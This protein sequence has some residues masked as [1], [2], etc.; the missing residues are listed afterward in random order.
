VSSKSHK[1]L[2]LRMI[3]ITDLNQINPDQK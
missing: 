1:A 2:K 3:F